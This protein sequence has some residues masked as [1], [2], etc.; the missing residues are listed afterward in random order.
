MLY[1]LA[2]CVLSLIIGCAWVKIN[3]T[4]QENQMYRKAGTPLL[5]N[6]LFGAIFLRSVLWPIAVIVALIYYMLVV[7]IE[8][9]N[10][11]ISPRLARVFL[12]SKDKV[13]SN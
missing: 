8:Y 4:L 9:T 13:D 6:E 2:Y 5:P 7:P 1:F 3:P 12:P 10:K 11:K